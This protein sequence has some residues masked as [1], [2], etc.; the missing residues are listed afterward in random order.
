MVFFSDD[1]DLLASISSDGLLYVWRIMEG[2]NKEQSQEINV[3]QVMAVKVKGESETV[4]SL[5]SW[6]C[7]KENALAIGIGRSILRFNIEKVKSRILD[8]YSN[9][10]WEVTRQSYGVHFVGEHEAQLTDLSMFWKEKSILVSAANDGTIKLWEEASV[11]PIAEL[12]LGK[13]VFSASFLTS[14]Y[15]PDHIILVTGASS[16]VP[17]E[18]EVKLWTST[19]EDRRLG[20]K[21]GELWHCMQTLVFESSKASVSSSESADD[22]IL[23]QV[24]AISQTGLLLLADAKV[25]TVYAIHLEYGHNP[26]ATRMDYITKFTSSDPKLSFT[27]FGGKEI[28]QL[29]CVLTRAIN[30]YELDIS[31]CLPPPTTE[32]LSLALPAHTTE[33]TVQQLQYFQKTLS[34]LITMQEGMDNK[35]TKM[36]CYSLNV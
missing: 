1:V 18:V 26:A 6:N 7:R 12:R 31:H 19:V 28:V 34:R 13:A 27:V 3:C 23:N 21:A 24:L 2:N 11:K 20:T 25:K 8:K 5:V 32:S 15:C 35:I 30:Q 10:A 9:N 29:Y 33:E 17:Q 4:H 36:G 22:L 16:S 14:P